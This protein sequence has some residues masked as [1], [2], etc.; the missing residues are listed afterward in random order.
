MFNG[1]V[2][3]SLLKCQSSLDLFLQLSKFSQVSTYSYVSVNLRNNA[4]A[5]K[6]LLFNFPIAGCRQ[7]AIVW[8]WLQGGGEVLPSQV[9]PWSG[10]TLL[11]L[12]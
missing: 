12:L 9:D 2:R 11:P 1:Y 6:I 3:S 5:S 4:I 10:V 8:A 7:V